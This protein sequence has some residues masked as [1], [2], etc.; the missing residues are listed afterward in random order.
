MKNGF[1]IVW[2]KHSLIE[3]GETMKYLETFWTEKEL[4]N[5]SKDLNNILKIISE[6]PKVFL[7]SSNKC[8]SI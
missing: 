8:N 4:R 1:R 3:L 6:K 7:D 5:F 2:S